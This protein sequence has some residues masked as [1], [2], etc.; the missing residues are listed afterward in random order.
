MKS[1]KKQKKNDIDNLQG[2]WNIVS[3]E[4]DGN[5]MPESMLGG[6]QITVKGTRFDTVSMGAAYSGVLTLDESAKPKTFD[7]KFTDGPEKGNTNLGI[8][9]LD[10][11]TWTLCLATRGKIRPKTFAT[12]P[13][14]GIALETLKR[15]KAITA[16]TSDKNK[17]AGKFGESE[18]AIPVDDSHLPPATGIHGEWVI[19]S[20]AQDGHELEPFMIKTGKRV[21]TGNG[22]TVSFAGQI[23]VQAKYKTD[24][25]KNPKTI[26]YVHTGGMHKGKTQVGI[27]A[28]DGRTLKVCFSAPGRN[29]RPSDFTTN[30]G[31]GRTITVWKLIGQ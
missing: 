26:D 12:K 7:L 27:C 6:S 20:G 24:N 3:L 15:A 19:V 22:L 25:Q 28:L 11:D 21:A 4:V 13:G 14:T 18:K 5:K 29:D 16:K 30:I 9:K 31:D 10:G 8:Y 17:L 1:T 23:I 2:T